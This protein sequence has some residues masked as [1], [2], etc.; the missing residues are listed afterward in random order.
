[1][2]VVVE[3]TIDLVDVLVLDDPQLAVRLSDQSGVVTHNDYSCK[4]G[5]REYDLLR[6]HFEEMKLQ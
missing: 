4:E 2:F 6:G 5:I 1:M 3:A